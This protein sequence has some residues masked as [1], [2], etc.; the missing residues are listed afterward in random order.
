MWYLGGKHRQAKA[1]VAAVAGVSPDF[2]IYVE[3]FAGAMWSATAMIQAF[4]DK[5]FY[6]SDVHPALMNFWQ[7]AIDGWDPPARVSEATYRQLNAL[8][9]PEDPMTGYVGFAWS[10]GGKFFGGAARSNG[11][12]KGSYSSTMQKIRLLRQADV[13]LACLDYR[14]VRPVRRAV[15][16]LDPPYSFGRTPQDRG[17]G[18]FDRAAFLEY[19]RGAA[20]ASALVLTSEFVN[21]GGFEVVHNWGDTVVRHLNATPPDGTSEL[22]MRVCGR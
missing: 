14:S 20:V 13:Q 16:Y 4:P 7:A 11:Q 6:L 22:L 2:G 21:D 5:Q 1:I 17:N 12:I 10:F 3:P 18:C 15:M 9:D 19:A 8:R